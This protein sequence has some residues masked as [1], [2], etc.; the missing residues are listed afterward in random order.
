MLHETGCFAHEVIA[1]SWVGWHTTHTVFRGED[2]VGNRGVTGPLI[3]KPVQVTLGRF[4]VLGHGR[5]LE[6]TLALRRAFEAAAGSAHGKRHEPSPWFAERIALYFSALFLIYGVHSSYFPVWLHWRGLGPEAIGYITA[7][8]IFLRTVLT[9]W[10]GAQADTRHNHRQMIIAMS[11]A[12]TGFALAVSQ[13]SGFWPIFALSVPFA[14]LISSIMPL[15]ET[16]AVTGVRTAGHDYG[17]MRLWGSAMFLVTTVVTG[18]LVDKDGPGIAIYVMIAAAF[19]TVGAALML[20]KPV[21]EGGRDVGTVK[22][23]VDSGLVTALL[24]KPMFVAFLFA[25]G[26]VMG[27]HATFYT[28]GALHLKEQGISGAAFGALWTISI[29]AEM[30]LLAFSAPLV[31]RFGPVRLLIAGAAGGVV[32]WGAMG[33]DPSFGIVVGLQV[34]HALT[35]GATHVGAIHFIARAVPHR[36]AGTAQALYSAIGSGLITGV[37]T[38]MAGQ[39]YPHLAGRTF[40][41]MA[42]LSG[43]GLAVAIWIE[44]TWDNKPIFGK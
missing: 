19:A 31:E 14:I 6:L 1:L 43:A 29:F 35:Y 16:L 11:V 22:P 7:V 15:T 10:I 13:C 2:R 27:S 26:A 41:V 20:P 37:A 24:S 42:A 23:P 21:G 30:A 4:F 34:L 28:F 33:L 44:K 39:F 8:P 18:T 36:G 9:P 17:R 32:R 3:E 12:C 40:L 5:M 25:V 38:I